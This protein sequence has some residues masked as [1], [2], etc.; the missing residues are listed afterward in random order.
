M[1]HIKDI[2]LH[3][4]RRLYWLFYVY[5]MKNNYNRELKVVRILVTQAILPEARRKA[6]NVMLRMTSRQDCLLYHPVNYLS[7]P[8][9]GE[10]FNN[11]IIV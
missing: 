5:M 7:L 11:L 9:T 8:V 6:R 10:R 2:F 1:G 3:F 4:Y